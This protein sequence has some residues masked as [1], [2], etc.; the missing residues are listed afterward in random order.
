MP[1]HTIMT[2][3]KTVSRASPAFSAAA[4][5]MTETISATSNGKNK[6]AERL[7]NPM[8]D[9]LGVVYGREHGGDQ[10]RARNRT[11]HAH[12]HQGGRVAAAIAI[13]SP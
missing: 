7:S 4:P 3:A 8:R 11:G 6:R 1:F 9:H 2:A 10:S 13:V 5:T 12:A